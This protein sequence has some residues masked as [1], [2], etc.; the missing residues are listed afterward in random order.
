MDYLDLFE[1]VRR[2]PSMYVG[3]ESFEILAAWVD[4]FDV[5]RSGGV[6]VGFREWLIVRCRGGNNLAWPALVRGLAGTT[7]SRDG[8]GKRDNRRA[9]DVMFALI[10]E[11]A[12][13]RHRR[14]LRAIL[15]DYQRWLWRQ[16]WYTAD[17]PGYV[18]P[19]GPRRKKS[20]KTNAAGKRR[21]ARSPS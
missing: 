7:D 12:K 17:R 13:D 10:E 9:I 11:F 3:G 2:R 20:K 21:R 5:A 18:A 6:L 8:M 16:S 15:F 4:G 19:P 1:K 14:G